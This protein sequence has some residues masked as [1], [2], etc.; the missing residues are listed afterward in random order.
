VGTFEIDF[1]RREM[2]TR[3]KLVEL[4]GGSLC[5]VFFSLY[6]YNMAISCAVSCER[7]IA[8]VNVSPVPACGSFI[9]SY[10]LLDVWL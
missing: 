3:E 2:E 5:L 6:L 7:A 1:E 10:L 8:C 4:V 9:A